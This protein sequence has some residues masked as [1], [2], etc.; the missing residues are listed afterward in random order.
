MKIKL[1]LIVALGLAALALAACGTNTNLDNNVHDND[2]LL[3]GDAST[4]EVVTWNLR[5]YPLT[6]VSKDLLAQI[7]P[8]LKVDLIAVQEVMDYGAFT[9][10]ADLIPYYDALIYSAT[11]TYRLAYLYDTRTV[12]VNSAYTIFDGDTNPFPRA[13]YVLDLTFQG[14]NLYVINNHLKAFGDNYI[15]ETDPW[16]E[17]YRRRLACQ[18]LDAYI[19]TNLGDEKVIVLGDFNDQIAEPEEY[20][21]FL[22]FLDKPDE[23]QFSDMA[24]AQNPINSAVSYPSSNSHIDH[25][26]ITNELFGSFASEGSLCRVINV[27]NWFGSWAAY[28]D[29]LSDHRPLALKLL[30]Q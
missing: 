12:Q 19:S 29:Q 25:I 9:E 14:Q 20:N 7:I 23:Y 3:F 26:L 24:I 5:T 8:Q 4:F 15:D 6:E 1:R 18:E 10:L 27:E 2:I 28:S 13:P 17:E 16:D 11:S 21:V 30:L 22:S